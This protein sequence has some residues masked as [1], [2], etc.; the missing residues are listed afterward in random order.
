MPRFNRCDLKVR[1]AHH[2]RWIAYLVYPH[3]LIR[4]RL[5]PLLI[6]ITHTHT[7]TPLQGLSDVGR[8]VNEAA[9]VKGSGAE[10]G[11]NG[12]SGGALRPQRGKGAVSNM[13]NSSNHS[14]ISSF[15]PVDY[16]CC[17]VILKIIIMTD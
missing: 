1:F 10:R 5:N 12:A 13:G 8:L 3:A 11:L 15:L 17:S 6:I 2:E 16:F 7:H 14:G 9:S 4:S